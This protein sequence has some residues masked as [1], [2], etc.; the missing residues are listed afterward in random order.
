MGQ[1]LFSYSFWCLSSLS[2]IFFGFLKIY[3]QFVKVFFHC[4]N[5]MVFLIFFNEG[6]IVT[7]RTEAAFSFSK[8]WTL[9][10]HFLLES[11]I[12]RRRS[13]ESSSASTATL[14]GSCTIS[15]IVISSTSMMFLKFSFRA[16]ILM[17]FRK[18]YETWKQFF[19]LFLPF[20]WVIAW[21]FQMIFI[22]FS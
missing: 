11:K 20:R 18:I 9:H 6:F 5:F 14:M 3:T 7:F 4:V 10:A 21:I 12:C 1:S 16:Y 17:N 15:T 2:F 22:L 8:R 19:L 13:R